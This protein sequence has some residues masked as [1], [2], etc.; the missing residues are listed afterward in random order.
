MYNVKILSKYATI[1][2]PKKT[3]EK[4]AK[5]RNER[6]KEQTKATLGYA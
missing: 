4:C 5:E 1:K 2:R 6:K 3:S